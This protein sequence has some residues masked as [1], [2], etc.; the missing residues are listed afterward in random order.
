[1]LFYSLNALLANER[2]GAEWPNPLSRSEAI[3]SPLYGLLI[4]DLKYTHAILG[5]SVGAN[6]PYKGDFTAPSAAHQHL[7]TQQ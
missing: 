6:G 4:M 5:T 1:M 2:R 3:L 7:T